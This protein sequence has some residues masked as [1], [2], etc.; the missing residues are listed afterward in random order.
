MYGCMN[1]KARIAV[2][3]AGCVFAI[4]GAAQAS[5]ISIS[6]DPST[7]SLNVGETLTVGVYVHV[8]GNDY[9]GTNL[10]FSDVYAD[11][12]TS[13][14]VGIIEPS[15][16]T[17]LGGPTGK[18]VM[19]W[20]SGLDD[21]NKIKGLWNDLDTDTDADTKWISLSHLGNNPAPSGYSAGTS[22]MLIATVTY[23]A[24]AVGT[25]TLSTASVEGSTRVW[26][27]DGTDFSKVTPGT[28]SYDSAEI[29]VVPEPGTM[30]LLALGALALIRR[31]E[32]VRLWR[33]GSRQG[34]NG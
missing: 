16:E 10:G 25:A 14:T 30:T 1:S 3:A 27:F 9:L 21:F 20:A 19:S 22:N 24:L 34:R 32:C 4:C 31:R 13:G 2:I 15:A 12:V 5:I 33:Q 6:L 26:N 23:E 28:F 18:V 17:G 8:T 7:T 29:T 11:L